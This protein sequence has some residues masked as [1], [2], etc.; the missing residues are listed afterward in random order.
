MDQLEKY[1]LRCI[2]LPCEGSSENGARDIEGFFYIIGF[3]G[4]LCNKVQKK[5]MTSIQ[6]KYFHD[7]K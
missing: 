2:K 6:L 5:M 7:D 1:R 3:K 4:F